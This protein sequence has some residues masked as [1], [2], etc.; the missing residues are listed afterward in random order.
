[1]NDGIQHSPDGRS[2]RDPW[3]QYSMATVRELERGVWLDGSLPDDLRHEVEMLC[4]LL[5]DCVADLVVSL[6]MFEHARAD[7]HARMH[8]SAR[9]DQGD[10]QREGDRRR[11][12]EA[13]LE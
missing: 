6:S 8:A 13:E 10:W 4:H 2:V 7:D 1:M 5:S 9:P 12:R 3:Y 11:A